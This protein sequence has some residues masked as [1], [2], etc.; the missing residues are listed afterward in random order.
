VLAAV[1]D[2]K[3]QFIEMSGC[4]LKIKYGNN[5]VIKSHLIALSIE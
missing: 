1:D 4:C 2:G 3:A 5:G